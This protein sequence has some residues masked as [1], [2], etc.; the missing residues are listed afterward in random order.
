MS[1]PEQRSRPEGGLGAAGNAVAAHPQDIHDTPAEHL[2][3]YALLVR[4][5][6]GRLNRRLYLSLPAAVK[7]AE[8]AQER[9]HAATLELVRLVPQSAGREVIAD[10]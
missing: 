7:A 2:P 8:R 1:A 6:P 5:G 9:G 10:A 3:A 4:T